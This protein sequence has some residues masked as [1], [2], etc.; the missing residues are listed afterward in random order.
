MAMLLLSL[1]GNAILYQGEELGLPQAHV[2][3]EKLQDPEGIANWPRTLGR[4]GARTPFCWDSKLPNAGFSTSEPWLPIDER[5]VNLAANNQTE[6][7]ESVLSFFKRAI[8]TRKQHAALRYG[9]IKFIEAPTG[10]VSFLRR[11][12]RDNLLITL[13][14]SSEF[15]DWFPDKID[16]SILLQTSAYSID[17]RVPQTLE[18]YSGYIAS[19]S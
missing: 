4:D 6:D 7:P 16:G 10:V 11:H 9:D 5:H 3:F 12:R 13:N 2:P 18:P 1:R 14:L 8:H 15:V 19:T 17:G